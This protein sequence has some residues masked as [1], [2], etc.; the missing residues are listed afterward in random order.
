M[1]IIWKNKGLLVLLY[2]F[3]C[4][5]AAAV[6]L[7]YLRRNIGG[8]FIQFD[9][10]I[11]IGIGLLFASFWTYKTKDNFYKDQ[12]GVKQKMDTENELFF[13]SMKYWVFILLLFGLVLIS[14]PLFHFF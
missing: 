10:L 5:F 9:D 7:G 13:I 8:I 3:V 4:T 1:I 14:N 6:L 12:N 2:I 11:A